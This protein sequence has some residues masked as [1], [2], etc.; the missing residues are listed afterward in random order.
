MNGLTYK[1]YSESN[2][3]L[4]CDPGGQVSIYSAE[5]L[6]LFAYE[7]KDESC[8]HNSIF[9]TAQVTV[10]EDL[11]MSEVSNM[12]PIGTSSVP[13]GGIFEG[14]KLKISKLTVKLFDYVEN[15]KIRN[16]LLDEMNTT[17]CAPFAYSVKHSEIDNIFVKGFEFQYKV[18]SVDSYVGGLIGVISDGTTITNCRVDVGGEA[19]QETVTIPNSLTG[20]DIYCNTVMYCG[21]IVGIAKGDNN[22]IDNCFVNWTCGAKAGYDMYFGG[23]CGYSEKNININNTLIYFKS[24]YASNGY[25]IKDSGNSGKVQGKTAFAGSTNL[26]SVSANSSLSNTYVFYGDIEFKKLSCRNGN[27]GASNNNQP[28]V[29]YYTVSTDT[30][31]LN[32]QGFEYNDSLG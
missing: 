15:A 29:N 21:G 2:N 32:R 6:K 12:I 20:T 23:A 16:I 31:S 4:T 30:N 28:L 8:V 17:H 25:Y 19:K 24:G 1:K 18:K 27:R 22:K 14:N 9:Q 26:Y 3:F 7:L 13:F 5:A 11:D 10:Y